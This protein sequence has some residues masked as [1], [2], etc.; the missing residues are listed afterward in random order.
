[1]REE[2]ASVGSSRASASAAGSRPTAWASCRS[3]CSAASRARRSGS[4]ATPACSSRCCRSSSR[5]VGF[6]QESRYHDLT[7]DE[8]TFAVVQA[9]AD[10]RLPAARAAGGALPRPRQAARRAG[11][12]TTGGCT[13]TRGPAT[14]TTRDVGAEL[15]DA[16]L[17]RL[18]YPNRAARARGAD[19]PLPHVQ[20]RQ[21]ATRCARAGCWRATARGSR[22]TCSTTRRPTCCGK[23]DEG[24]RDV[25]ELE[26][27]QRF[28]AVV[29][30]ERASPHRL[31]DLAVD[32]TDLIELGY[33]PGPEL[34]AHARRR[35][36]TAVVDDPA[37]N[38]ARHAARARE[39][40]AAVVI[41]W[42]APG[43]YVVAF[44]TRV[45]GVSEGPFDSLNLGGR[46]DDPARV[47]ENRRRAC[48]ALGLDASRLAV[49]RQ[50]HTPTVHRARRRV[51]AD[52]PGDG[53]WTRRAR[54][55]RCS[56]SRPTAC[57]SRSRAAD[58]GA[59]ALAVLHAGW[60]GLAEGV[61]EAGVRALGGGPRRAVVGPAVG[62]CCYEV[63]PGGVGAVRRRPD[64]A[65]GSSTCG[66]RPSGRCGAR[67][68][69]SRARR[70]L[71]A[72][73]SGALLLAPPHRAGAR[74][75]GRARC[76]RR[77]SSA[78]GTSASA[79]RSAR[80]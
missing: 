52:E 8:H 74:R 5:A 68:S 80:A 75:P 59:P 67:A 3:C 57:R 27:L 39:G 53:L 78:S 65:T 51:D 29:E 2:A 79:P 37:L 48:D 49:N 50:R 56:R 66:R 69:R 6:D 7:V 34:G 14:A 36:S 15:A 73:Q 11:A 18:R 9:T 54:S 31:S 47:A 22:S 62:P 16:A 25:H 30:Q 26:R 13:S 61:V 35:C 77:L 55:C 44:T 23:G 38:R 1:M 71:H 32:G 41:R 12:A 64:D 24:P 28:R 63:G 4:R 70:P 60:R 33:Q 21:G 19:R 58:G 43:P 42:D 46:R 17:R 45:G 76:C 40:A 20:H 10:A 72:L